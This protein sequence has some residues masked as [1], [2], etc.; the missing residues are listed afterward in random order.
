MI[1]K[2]NKF[3]IARFFFNRKVRKVDTKLNIFYNKKL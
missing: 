3:T 1:K 2:H